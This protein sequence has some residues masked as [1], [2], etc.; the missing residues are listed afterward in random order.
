MI[1]HLIAVIGLFTL[2]VWNPCD[3]RQLRFARL[4]AVTT[5]DMPRPVRA[6]FNSTQ[7]AQ[8]FTAWRVHAGDALHASFSDIQTA[9]KQRALHHGLCWSDWD[10]VNAWLLERGA[11]HNEVV[12]IHRP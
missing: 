3:F 12:I 9:R 2:L 11:E 8:E 4:R 1:Y 7:R 6:A 10:V 5:T